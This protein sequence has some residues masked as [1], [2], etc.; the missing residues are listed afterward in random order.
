MSQEQRR[1]WQDCPLC[2][3]SGKLAVGM[4]PEGCDEAL[5][6]VIRSLVTKSVTENLIRTRAV[7]LLRR[8]WQEYPSLQRK[9]GSEL[10]DDIDAFLQSKEVAP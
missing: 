4:V 3:G 1:P 7:A 9:M 2:L 8:I 6:Q 5:A 10:I